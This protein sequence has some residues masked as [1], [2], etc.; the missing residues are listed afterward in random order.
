MQPDRPLIEV[1][2]LHI[3][4][5]VRSSGVGHR[6]SPWHRAVNGVSLCINRGS[7][8][9]LV[10]E[11]G[12]GKTTLGRAILRRISPNR[13]A[14][15]FDGRDLATATRARRRE[16]LRGMQMIFQDASSSLNPR[17]TIGES[18][19]EPLVVQGNI[20]VSGR[21]ARREVITRLLEDVGL[22]AEGMDRYPHELSGGQ[23]QRVAIARALAAGPCFVVCDEPVSALDLSVR[24]QILNLLADMQRRRGLTYLLIAHDL[25]LVRQVADRVAVMFAGRV[26][27]VAPASVLFDRPSHPYTQALWEASLRPVSRVRPATGGVG[28]SAP[29][30]DLGCAYAPRC[31][32]AEEICR[33]ET[34]VLDLRPGFDPRHHVACHKA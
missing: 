33:R 32:L 29:A 24:S 8:V 19:A 5:F 10:G 34:P 7:T 9:A 3:W 20:A 11:S 18:V 25:A 17:L 21:A 6:R 26:V 31:P 14:V 12:S 15:K 22:S 2:D 23:R 30:A 1:E 4:Y 13:G 16:L 28:L 27:E